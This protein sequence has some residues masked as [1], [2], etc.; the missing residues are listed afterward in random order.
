MVAAHTFRCQSEITKHT[1]RRMLGLLEKQ[2][3]HQQQQ[4]NK[5]KCLPVVL[6]CWSIRNSQTSYSKAQYERLCC[7]TT[8]H[9]FTHNIPMNV[10]CSHECGKVYN[11]VKLWFDEV[12]YSQVNNVWSNLRIS[13]KL[14]DGNVLRTLGLHVILWENQLNLWRIKYT[15]QVFIINVI[16]LKASYFL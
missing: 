6:C 3:Q 4:R 10:V 7:N 15:V 2:Q 5:W 11:N 16:F 1:H 13:V 12:L 8:I 14:F 9:S